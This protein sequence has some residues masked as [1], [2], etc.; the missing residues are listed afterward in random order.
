MEHIG[1]AFIF[2]LCGIVASII[3][4]GWEFQNK[5]RIER[6]RVGEKVSSVFAD[7]KPPIL[8]MPDAGVSWENQRRS[9]SRTLQLD[10]MPR[11]IKETIKLHAS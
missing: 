1:G 4:G 11:F 7:I 6:E 10:A 8:A 3:V 2:M 5:M 9:V